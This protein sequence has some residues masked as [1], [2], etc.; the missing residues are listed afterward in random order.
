MSAGE[1]AVLVAS[2]VSCLAVGGLL[3][4]LRSLRRETRRLAAV[5]R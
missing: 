1:I 5:C 4:A 3:V 2:V